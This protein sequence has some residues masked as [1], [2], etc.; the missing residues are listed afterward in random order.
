MNS[1]VKQEA[2]SLQGF[3]L[4]QTFFGFKPSDRVNLHD[5][6]FD[7][8][9]AGEGRW[10]WNDIYHMP[11][12]LRKFYVKKLNSIYEKQKTAETTRKKKPTPKD[13]IAKPPM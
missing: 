4:E 5:Q 13:K 3:N 6:L 1:K 11:L 12:F 2:P 8:I 10:T 7:I 9:W